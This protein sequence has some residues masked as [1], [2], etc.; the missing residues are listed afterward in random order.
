MEYVNENATRITFETDVYQTYMFDLVKKQCF[1]EREHVNDDT[2]G[3]NTTHEG[4]DTGEF[5]VNEVEFKF[6]FV[7]IIPQLFSQPCPTVALP[8][9]C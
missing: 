8:R 2:I 3:I 4:I 5:I 7:F 6:E 1:V 9:C